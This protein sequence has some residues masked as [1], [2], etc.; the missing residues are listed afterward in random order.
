MGFTIIVLIAVVGVVVYSKSKKKKTVTIDPERSA[1]LR[2]A[3]SEATI[4]DFDEFMRKFDYGGVL[5]N[6]FNSLR[7]AVL[8]DKYGK[9]K[10]EDKVGKIFKKINEEVSQV[11]EPGSENYVNF[12]KV[13]YWKVM[14]EMSKSSD[15]KMV[16]YLEYSISEREEWETKGKSQT[17]CKGM[18][19]DP[20]VATA[21]VIMAAVAKCLYKNKKTTMFRKDMEK[22][23]LPSM[24]K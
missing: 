4:E 15:P 6:A 8:P 1:A 10:F 22:Y 13:L 7:Q 11:L 14:R 17:F 24:T 16:E 19:D 9:Y 2:A 5:T 18:S 12:F 21:E 20:L 23:N 3:S